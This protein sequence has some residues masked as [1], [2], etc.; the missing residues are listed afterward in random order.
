MQQREGVD[1]A[2]GGPVADVHPQVGAGLQQRAQ[3]LAAHP[4]RQRVEVEPRRAGRSAPRGGSPP[5]PGARRRRPRRGPGRARA[6]R[7]RAARVPGA[8]ACAPGPGARRAR[9]APAPRSPRRAR[10]AGAR[11]SARVGAAAEL[12]DLVGG[13]VVVDVGDVD[14][15]DLDRQEAER[16]PRP[17]GVED[18]R[19]DVVAALGDGRAR[20]VEDVLGV[21]AHQVVQAPVV[22]PR[23]WARSRVGTRR[24]TPRLAAV[25]DAEL[26][27]VELVGQRAGGSR[28]R[29]TQRRARRSGARAPSRLRRVALPTRQRLLVALAGGLLPE[30]QVRPVERVEVPDAAPAAR[31]PVLERARA[32]RGPPRAGPQISSLSATPPLRR[33]STATS[34]SSSRT[35]IGV[36]VGPAPVPSH[37]RI[38][39]T[40]TTSRKLCLYCTQSH[41]TRTRSRSASSSPSASS[42]GVTAVVRSTGVFPRKRA[43]GRRSTSMASALSGNG[44]QR[45][46]RRIVGGPRSGENPAA[47]RMSGTPRS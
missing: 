30:A 17:R 41:T 21:V 42:T 6:R 36:G 1:E 45:A 31:P 11:G 12:G 7:R 32:L 22:G 14:E 18:E 15:E 4:R 38:G 47:A 10:P 39:R 25:A 35:L 20:Q 19:A 46:G 3:H 33:R 43:W 24:G 13:Q 29:P 34:R 5:T 9:R 26:D 37:E 8:A 28:A 44:G 23:P 40:S 2:R 27:D 16:G